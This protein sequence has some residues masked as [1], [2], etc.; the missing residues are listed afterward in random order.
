MSTCIEL[1]PCDW[2]IRNLRKRAVGQV[3]LIKWLVS[4]DCNE[5]KQA[6][7]IKSHNSPSDS[8]ISF[9]TVT[10]VQCAFIPG[11]T[12]YMYFGNSLA[13]LGTVKIPKNYE[14]LGIYFPTSFISSACRF[15]ASDMQGC[16]GM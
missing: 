10:V 9:K 1:L 13:L 6:V 4:V 2:L 12:L 16:G 3:Y 7:I 5:V 11:S 8:A 15:L 14:S